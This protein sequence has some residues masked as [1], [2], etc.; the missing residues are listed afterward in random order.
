MTLIL[1]TNKYWFCVVECPLRIEC[2]EEHLLV[3]TSA[4]KESNVCLLGR[5]W[6]SLSCFFDPSQV[7]KAVVRQILVV[8]IMLHAAV[9]GSR[10][11]L[12]RNG[13]CHK[14]HVI[15][16]C[17][18]TYNDRAARQPPAPLRSGAI[19]PTLATWCHH[20]DLAASL[21]HSSLFSLQF[22]P[23]LSVADAPAS[24]SACVRCMRQRKV[25]LR[26]AWLKV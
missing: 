14:W 18:M 2:F 7:S 25:R 19:S 1:A 12:E 21:I 16:C 8:I 4:S 11:A 5:W 24:L 13:V 17:G 20:K 10:C 6:R 26:L 3:V 9:V 22:P 23:I 15:R